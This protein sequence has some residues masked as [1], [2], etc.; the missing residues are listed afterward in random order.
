MSFLSLISRLREHKSTLL[1]HLNLC[2][3]PAT[4]SSLTSWSLARGG[5]TETLESDEG[6]TEM[7]RDPPPNSA[8]TTG[9]ELI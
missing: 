3:C 5:A 1:F 4:V 9:P 8:R 7:H 2:T 6:V